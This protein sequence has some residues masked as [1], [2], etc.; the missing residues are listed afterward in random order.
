MDRAVYNRLFSASTVTHFL[1]D[2]NQA[3]HLLSALAAELPS[4]PQDNA[5]AVD[6][7]YRNL[8]REY[9]N[10][11]FYKNTLLNN[12]VLGRHSMNTTVALRE[13]PV[14][15]SILDFL[16]INGVGHVYEV[17]TGLDN[18]DRLENQLSD[19]YKAFKQVSVVADATHIAALQT[20]LA[21]TSTGIIQ[22]KPRGV[23][24]QVKAAVPNA[25]HLDHTIMFKMLR[26]P[27]YEAIIQRHFGQLPEVKPVQLFR[28]CLAL[29]RTLDIETAHAELLRALKARQQQAQK[30]RLFLQVPVALRDLVYFMDLS[31]SQYS[32][33]FSFLHRTI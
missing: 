18:L 15:Q 6:A 28:A 2:Q 7:V 21:D 8:A 3:Q 29:Y 11:Y 27:E 19:Y 12:I 17:K 1:S 32:Q 31:V 25:D 20:M 24:S 4:P 13:V 26:K 30:Q 9:R 5:E 23:L 16:I 14:G 10:E 33:L 22:M